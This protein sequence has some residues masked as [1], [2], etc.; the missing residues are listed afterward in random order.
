MA[1]QIVH[2]KDTRSKMEFTF[3]NKESSDT[4]FCLIQNKVNIYNNI[5]FYT[6][7]RVFKDAKYVSRYSNIRK[8]TINNEECYLFIIQEKQYGDESYPCNLAAAYGVMVDGLG[9]ITNDKNL[10]SVV[11]RSIG[12]DTMNGKGK[13]F[14]N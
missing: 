4:V 6:Q 3:K 8:I 1:Y 2:T 7:L 11:Q 14:C 12:I 9:Y 10:L 13:E 5:E